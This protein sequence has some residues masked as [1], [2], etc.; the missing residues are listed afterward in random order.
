MT[1]LL[2]MSSI[3]LKYRPYGYSPPYMDMDMDTLHEGYL[4]GVCNFPLVLILVNLAVII[5]SNI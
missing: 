5:D 2:H 1:V 4:R 3:K